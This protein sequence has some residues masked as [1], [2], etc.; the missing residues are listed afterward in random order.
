MRNRSAISLGLVL[1][2]GLVSATGAG[3]APTPQTKNVA[4]WVTAL[5]MDGPQVAYATDGSGSANCFKLFTWNVSS[6]AGTLVSGPRTGSCGSDEPHGQRI[7]AVALAGKR[8]AWIRNITGNTEADDY[9]FTATLPAPVEKKLTS[10]TRTGD[11]DG[12]ALKG[13]WVKGLVGSGTVLAANLWT[14]DAAG[15]VTKARLSSIGATKTATIATGTATLAAASADTGRVAVAHA[16]GTVGIYSAT[17]PLL[18][19]IKPT[20]TRLVS[21]RKD[22]LVVLTK[23]KTL[24]IYNSHTGAFI[25]KWSVPGGAGNLDVNSNIAIFSV[26]RKLYAVQLTTGKQVVI[27]TQKRAIAAAEIEAPGIAYAYNTI[28]GIKDIGNIAFVPLATVRA[29]VS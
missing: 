26:W 3:A 6:H 14:T 11:T 15:S 25:R 2:C 5:A 28:K 20:S 12:D 21:L 4:G 27:A 7:V 16:D 10:A 17:G 29:A 22:F 8:I 9:L 23:S 24:E 1:A 13:N 18:Q 19:T